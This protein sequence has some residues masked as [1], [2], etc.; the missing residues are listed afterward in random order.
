MVKHILKILQCEH[1]KI[2]KKLKITCSSQTHETIYDN[3]GYLLLFDKQNYEVL[4][5]RMN[6]SSDFEISASFF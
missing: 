6:N 3:S 2:F 5:F 4:K 1:R